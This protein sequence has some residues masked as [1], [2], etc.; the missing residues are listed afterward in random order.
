MGLQRLKASVWWQGRSRV[1]IGVLKKQNNIMLT[2]EDKPKFL[3]LHVG[4]NDIGRLK[5]SDLRE[6]LK[7]K[8]SWLKRILP[9]TC[10]IWSQILPRALWRYSEEKKAME[11]CR[12]RINNAVAK[13]VLSS[14]GR[15]IR[16]PDILKHQAISFSDLMGST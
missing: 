4:V 16:H 5:T 1:G 14:G 7:S 13:F 8:I 15:Y 12:Y 10:I 9:N 11:R 6:E 3:V 2:Y